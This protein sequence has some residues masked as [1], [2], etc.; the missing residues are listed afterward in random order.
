MHKKQILL[1][2]IVTLL[3]VLIGT[4]TWG[5]P[6]ADSQELAADPVED[7]LQPDTAE[8]LSLSPNTL[9]SVDLSVQ[10]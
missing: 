4:I 1:R 3:A 6:A 2:L 5:I 9:I 7:S 10:R 8:K